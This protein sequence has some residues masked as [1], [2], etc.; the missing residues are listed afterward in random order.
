MRFSSGDM[1]HANA[2]SER[3]DSDASPLVGSAAAL[4]VP[5]IKFV[6]HPEGRV[7]SSNLPAQTP[8]PAR[9]EAAKRAWVTI[10]KNRAAQAS[11]SG[12]G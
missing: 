2:P 8:N 3:M 10:R 12:K 1:D 7:N 5:K 11:A 4:V 9:S 6:S